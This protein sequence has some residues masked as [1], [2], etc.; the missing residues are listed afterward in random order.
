MTEMLFS[1]EKSETA[2]SLKIISII[3]PLVLT[4]ANISNMVVKR[5]FKSLTF[6]LY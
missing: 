1:K 5:L 3:S 6:K 4:Q 2:L